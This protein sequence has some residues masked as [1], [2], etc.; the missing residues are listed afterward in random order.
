M[1]GLESCF[2]SCSF[3]LVSESDVVFVEEE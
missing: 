1:M 3:C 2:W